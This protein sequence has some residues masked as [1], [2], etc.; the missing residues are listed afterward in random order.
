MRHC[1]EERNHQMKFYRYIVLATMGICLVGQVCWAENRYVTDS[2]KITMR[3]GPS[4]QNKIIIM[5]RSGEPVEVMETNEGWSHVRL[6]EREGGESEGW[7]MSRY[8]ISRLPWES[9]A[10]VL[11]NK[12]AQIKEKLVNLEKEW[13][14]TGGREKEVT[15]ELRETSFKLSK[16]QKKHNELKKG[17]ANFIQLKKDYEE[18]KA[19]MKK[20]Q[21]NVDRLETEN[22]ILRASQRNKWLGMG[23]LILLCGLFIGIAM[24]KHQKKQKSN[25]L[26]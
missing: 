21:E 17:A 4:L 23:A 8:L 6:P 13:K 22:Q 16:L 3:T 19:N 12:N 7:V 24:G 10:R 26:Y 5:L 9:Q 25:V 1:E 18:I 20:S 2:F 14:V 15:R 11:R